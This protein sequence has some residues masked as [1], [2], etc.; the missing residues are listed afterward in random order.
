VCNYGA[1]DIIGKIFS[2]SEVIDLLQVDY[3]YYGRDGGVTFSGGEPGMQSDFAIALGKAIKNEGLNLCIQTCG[4]A[5][6][7]FYQQIHQYTDIFL[8]DWKASNNEKHKN[9]TGVSNASILENLSYLNQLGKR[10]ILR[11]PMLPEVNDTK[12][13]LVK[14]AELYK[15]YK[16]IENVELLPYHTMGESKKF[17]IGREADLFNVRIPDDNDKKRWITTLHALGCPAKI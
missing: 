11:C 12:E 4:F 8:F 3:P 1:V 7:E 16:A 17:Q 5:D 9:I 14:I 13:D 15:K 6:T 2:V 10:I